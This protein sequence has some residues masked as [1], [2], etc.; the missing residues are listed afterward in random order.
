MTVRFE[1]L[2]AETA[3]VSRTVADAVPAAFAKLQLQFETGVVH[4]DH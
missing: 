3:F 2:F 1:V 4:I